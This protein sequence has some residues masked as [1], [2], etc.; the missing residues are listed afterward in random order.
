MTLFYTM[1]DTVTSPSSPAFLQNGRRHPPSRPLLS[2]FDKRHCGNSEPFVQSPDHFERV[3][4]SSLAPEVDAQQLE[5]AFKSR[6]A[7]L[8]TGEVDLKSPAQS[9]TSKRQKAKKIENGPLA[10]GID[11][12]ALTLSEPRR[13]RDR[14]HVKAVAQHP[15]LICGR[16]P[17]DAH[18]L[19]YTQSRALGR[20]VSDEFTVPLCRG[21]HREV[22]RCGDES[23]WWKKTGIDPT[24]PARA[25]WLETHPLSVATAEVGPA[26]E[27]SDIR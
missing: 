23:G 14:N 7:T 22:H 3:A 15:C 21:H 13:I 5:D 27:G 6:L 17:S 25:L 19:R 24:V 26:A 9:P 2:D 11:K 16:R 18:H 12:S 1:S 10:D 8:A 4:F 20:K